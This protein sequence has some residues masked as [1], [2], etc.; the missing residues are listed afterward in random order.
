MQEEYQE[1]ERKRI[2]RMRSMMDISRGV[3]FTLLG[4]FFV[5]FDKFH[6]EGVLFHP[7]YRYLGGLFIVYGLWRFYSGIKKNYFR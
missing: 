4:L 7:W 1:Q 5:F 2:T 3:V 6:I